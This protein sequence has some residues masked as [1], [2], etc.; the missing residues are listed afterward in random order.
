VGFPNPLSRGRDIGAFLGLGGPVSY[1]INATVG[2]TSLLIAGKIPWAGYF[3]NWWTWW[4]GDTIG[5]LIV[6]PLLL[7]WLAEPRDIWRCRRLSVAVPL[8]GA[9]MLAVVVFVHASG[10]EQERQQLT[11]ERQAESLAYTLDDHFDRYLEL[12]RS[13][14]RF[15]ASSQEVKGD[16]FRTFVHGALAH[17]PGIQALSW[18][19]C[20]PDG[21]REA[22][23][24]AVP[25]E[26]YADFQITEQDA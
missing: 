17:H 12:L 5:I 26:G 25:Q 18:D 22:Y 7:S 23:E 1:L 10:Q 9:F 19:R 15:Y 16:E 4:I 24:E 2:V 3:H 14:A 13:I 6:T 20:V 11:F 8:V 21:L